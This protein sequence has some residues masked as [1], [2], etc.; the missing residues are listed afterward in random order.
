MEEHP[1]PYE[2]VSGFRDLHGTISLLGETRSPVG[3]LHYSVLRVEKGKLTLAAETQYTSEMSYSGGALAADRAGTLW[4]GNGSGIF[5]LRNG[6][7]ER[8]E[9]PPDLAGKRPRIA[10]VDADGRIWFGFT[11]NTV[12]VMDGTEVRTFSAKDGIQVGS[13][14]AITGRDPHIWIGGEGGLDVLLGTGFRDVLPADGDTFHGVSGI[15][16]DSGG[17]LFLNEQRGVVFVPATEVSKVLKDPSARVQYRLFDVRDGLPGPTQQAMTL[18]GTDGRIWFSTSLGVAWIDP[19]HIPK[20]PLPPPI[21][22]RAITANG[23]RYTSPAGLRLPPRTRDLTIDYTGLSLAVPDRVRFRYKLE[24][25]DTQWQDAGTRR[26]AFYTNLSPGEYRFRV[27]ACNNDGVWNESGAILSF[28]VTPAWYQTNFFRVSC[29]LAG[30]LLLWA[31]HRLRMRQVARAL[32][33]RFDERLSER[34]RIAREIHDTLIQTI[35]GSKLVADDALDQSADP[36]RMRHAL[37][38]LSEWLNRAIQEGRASLNSLRTSAT[39]TNDLAEGLRRAIEECR[40]FSPIVASFSVTGDSREMHPVVRDE[41]YRIGYEAIRNAS[42]HSKASRL[43]VGL[44]YGQDLAISVGDNGVG[45][46]E[47]IINGGADGHYGLQG[48]RERASRIGGELNIISSVDSGTEVSLV[49][50][51]R[52]AFRRAN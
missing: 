36:A 46:P 9:G 19:A 2:I 7:W 23:I 38:Q 37:E 14:M 41:I 28:L 43:H 15:Q 31:L 30:L 44:K 5:S 47:S 18:Q 17:D 24:G 4:I 40:M 16:E 10:T 35:Q 48:M 51:G 21:V 52:I 13:V 49:V 27:I 12:L 32:S 26:Q 25:L 20:N 39:E 22:I 33:L 45:I 3:S 6:H 34:T 42:A 11:E 50:P 29:F 1:Q 8:F